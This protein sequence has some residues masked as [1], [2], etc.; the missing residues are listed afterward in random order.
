MKQMR[1]SRDRKLMGVA[2]GMAEYFDM[3]VTLWRAIWLVATLMFPPLLLAYLILGLIMPGAPRS[4]AEEVIDVTPEAGQEERRQ[5]E[6]G[7]AAARR[8]TKSHDR[9]VSGVAAGI[10]EY[11]GVDPVLI[12][13]LFLA[14][15]FLGGAGVLVYIILAIIMPPP[16]RYA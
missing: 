7:D 5:G 10:A 9:W 1:R 16:T 13:A 12:R 8:M 4:A 3:D 11:L 2:A 15:I 6:T 14:S